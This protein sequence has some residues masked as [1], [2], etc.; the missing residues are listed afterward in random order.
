MSRTS[1][2]TSSFDTQSTKKNTT[3]LERMK[4][5]CNSSIFVI[6]IIFVGL[7]ISLLVIGVSI[8]VNCIAREICLTMGATAISVVLINVTYQFWQ[9]RKLE[10]TIQS[11]KQDIPQLV[12][13]DIETHIKIGKQNLNRLSPGIPDNIIKPGKREDDPIAKE[14]IE[15]LSSKNNRYFYIGIGMT[16]MANAIEQLEDTQLKYAFF[17]IPNPKKGFVSDDYVNKMKE[18]VETILKVWEDPSKALCVEFVFLNYPPLLHIHKTENDCWFAFVD[19][20]GKER[21]PVTYQ[22]K[23][24]EKKGNDGLEMY[25]TIAN[26]VDKLYAKNKTRVCYIFDFDKKVKTGKKCIK[27]ENFIALFNKKTKNK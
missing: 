14:L 4:Y 26:M 3:F 9:D 27:K 21:Y 23:K 10:S 8:E 11:I 15:S 22:Y 24:D 17:L 7:G 1:D 25:H 18:S 16:T 12:R 13:N 20:D 2:N 19:I 5:I 6:C